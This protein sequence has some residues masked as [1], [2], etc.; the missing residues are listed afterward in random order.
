MH[1]FFSLILVQSNV[2][3]QVKL[4]LYLYNVYQLI[5]RA[6]KFELFSNSLF[7]FSYSRIFKNLRQSLNPI[8]HLLSFS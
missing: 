4:T 5:L 6:I 2:L 7:L 3:S 1:L 8:E